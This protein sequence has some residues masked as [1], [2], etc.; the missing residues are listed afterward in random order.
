MSISTQ[1][2]TEIDI[3]YGQLDIVIKWCVQNIENN[4]K[5]LVLDYGGK[6]PGRYEFLFDNE[7]DYCKFLMWNK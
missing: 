2:R 3:P 5:Y 4:W 6:D 7:K 1:Y